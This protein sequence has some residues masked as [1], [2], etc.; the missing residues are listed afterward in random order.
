MPELR[1]V[2]PNFRF[3]RPSRRL[4]PQ[5]QPTVVGIGVGCGCGRGTWAQKG[6]RSPSM[7]VSRRLGSNCMSLTWLGLGLGLGIGIGLAIGLGFRLGL[8]LR[9]GLG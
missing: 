9:L 3:D 5:P 4:Q 6:C 8:G 2:N 7:A 1:C